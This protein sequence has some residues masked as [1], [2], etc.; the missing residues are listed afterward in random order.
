M[1]SLLRRI[2][3]LV[4]AELNYSRCETDTDTDT[5]TEK[6][7]LLAIAGS[8]AGASIGR[9][10]VVAKG[11]GF[12]VGTVPL[13]AAGALAGLALYEAIRAITEADTSCVGAAATG[14]AAGAGVSAAIGTV[15]IATGGTA[16][17]VGMAPMIAAGA[18]AGLDSNTGNNE[19]VDAELDSLRRQKVWTSV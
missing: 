6:A 18:V 3:R 19:V 13:T 7:I 11:S 4:K 1:G 17:A 2:T 8:L 14:A 9:I 5:D 12:S 15:G 10:G 16:I